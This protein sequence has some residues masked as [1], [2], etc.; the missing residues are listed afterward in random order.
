MDGNTVKRRKC[1]SCGATY[2]PVQADGTAYFHA[3]PPEIITHAICDPKTGAVVTPEKREPRTN[4][5]NENPHPE[6]T[7]DNPRIVSEGHGFTE[8]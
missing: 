7:R 6:S 1:N 5:R 2:F 3:C 4:T 8:L